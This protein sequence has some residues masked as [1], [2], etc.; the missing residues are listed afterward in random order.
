MTDDDLDWLTCTATTT[1]H[2]GHTHRC[3]L[4]PGHDDE[5][6]LAVHRVA[7]VALRSRWIDWPKP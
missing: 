7:G 1:D 6:H 4:E 3:W 5:P 2:E